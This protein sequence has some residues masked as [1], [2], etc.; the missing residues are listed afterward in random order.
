MKEQ[1]TW[2]SRNRR[3]I[4][5]HRDHRPNPRDRNRAFENI[6]NMTDVDV[7][8]LARQ[9]DRGVADLAALRADIAVTIAITR[10]M[11]RRPC[12][13]PRRAPHGNRRR[14]LLSG[15]AAALLSASRPF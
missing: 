14:R 6:G 12:C 3:R 9:C 1:G 10:R 7:N 13:A 2:Q 15:A 11:D 4:P 8:F 5:S